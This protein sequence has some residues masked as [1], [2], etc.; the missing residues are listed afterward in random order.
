MKHDEYVAEEELGDYRA[1][2][3]YKTTQFT[4]K[5]IGIAIDMNRQPFNKNG[6]I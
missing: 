3:N 6:G 2:D 1:M 4:L 5:R